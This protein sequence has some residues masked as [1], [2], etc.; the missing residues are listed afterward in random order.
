MQLYI[1]NNLG[2]FLSIW[3]CFKNHDS[4][5]GIQSQCQRKYLSVYVQAWTDG[6]TLIT[7]TTAPTQR[8]DGA[9]RV[10]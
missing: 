5:R 6:M 4:I 9:K 7:N 10:L 2:Y 8:L 1:N 3:C